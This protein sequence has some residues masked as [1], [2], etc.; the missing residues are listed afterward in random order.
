M[1]KAK[2]IASPAFV[3]FRKHSLL[4]FFVLLMVNS[5][6]INIFLNEGY[7]L[8]MLVLVIPA[9]LLLHYLIFRLDQ[10]V[11]LSIQNR[12]IEVD[13]NSISIHHKNGHTD[14]HIPVSSF[15]LMVLQKEYKYEESFGKEILNQ[16]KGISNFHFIQVYSGNNWY[17]MRFMLDS[18]FMETKLNACIQE[19]RK[20]GIPIQYSKEPIDSTKHIFRLDP[21]K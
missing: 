18:H 11:A 17:T 19:W 20:T 12:Y 15:E 16:L 5:I 2:L 14:L 6:I 3:F 1:F 10:K 8:R 21:V 9:I 4:L 7:D 13:S